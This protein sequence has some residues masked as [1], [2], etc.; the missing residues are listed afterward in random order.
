LLAL[1]LGRND[2]ARELLLMKLIRGQLRLTQ[3]LAKSVITLG[4]FDG[5][6]LG[7]QQL[8]N[9]LQKQAQILQASR[10]VITFEPH[11]QEFFNSEKA[12]PRLMRLHEKWQYLTELETDYL[13]CL[14]FNRNLA[15]VTA[16]DFV[17]E[18]LVRQLG[19]KAIIIGDDFHFGAQRTG[20]ADLL[21]EL[22]HQYGFQTIQV[23]AYLYEGQRISSTRI[24]QT[25]QINNLSLANILLGKPYFLCGKVVHGD[26]RGRLWGFPT[27]NIHLVDKP[28][29]ISGIYIV[30]VHGID[31]SSLPGVASVGLRPMFANHVTMME[32]HLLDFDRDIY[33]CQL[34]V[35]FLQKLRD[36]EAF[37][38]TEQLIEQIDQDV[39][40]ARKF[41]ANSP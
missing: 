8:L 7:H 26:A 14:R 5:F 3:T 4:N 34:K 16:H 24:R 33:G 37:I 35:E 38:N 23:P 18:I 32:I 36:Q 9:E 15:Q 29:S 6:H 22:G 10:V 19:M 25:L 30:K 12:P 41:F 31:H 13:V 40:E 1:L 20:N 2:G 28:V 11:P 21:K 39:Q 27:A 17:S